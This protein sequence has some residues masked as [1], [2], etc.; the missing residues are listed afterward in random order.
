MILFY[1]SDQ[2]MLCC[3]N[4]VAHYKHHNF[5]T[6]CGYILKYSNIWYVTK[7]HYSFE[8]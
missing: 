7:N 4:N 5:I 2:V 6:P 8:P 1:T 3:I